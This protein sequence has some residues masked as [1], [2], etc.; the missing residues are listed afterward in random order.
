MGGL[1]DGTSLERP[2]TCEV[3]GQ[4]LAACVCPRGADGG[5]VLPRD[6]A[7]RVR[8]ERR[9]GKW[10]TVISGLDPV[11]TDLKGLAKELRAMLGA[12]GTVAGGEVEIQGDHKERILGELRARGYPA[13]G[14][15]G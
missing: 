5:V 6:Q 4:V 15:G 9:R 14:A 8:R 13:K 3:C 2:V 12:G 10:V 11:G 7:A 1:F